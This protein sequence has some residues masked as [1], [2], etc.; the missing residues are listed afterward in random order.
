MVSVVS[1]PDICLLAYFNNNSWKMLCVFYFYFYNYS[2]LL[3]HNIFPNT[4][5]VCYS[6]ILLKKHKLHLSHLFYCNHTCCCINMVSVTSASRYI[7][8]CYVITHV[9]KVDP[10]CTSVVR[11]HGISQN[12]LRQFRL[13]L[14]LWFIFLFSLINLKMHKHLYRILCVR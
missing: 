14:N 4:K 11:F 6:D 1:I 12:C 8:Q 7:M 2:F 10:R 3:Y 13:R 5:F 9:I